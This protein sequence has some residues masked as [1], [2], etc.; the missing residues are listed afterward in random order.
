M[1][2][3]DDSIKGPVV[4]WR[5]MKDYA[6]NIVSAYR[7]LDYVCRQ[8]YEYRYARGYNLRCFKIKRLY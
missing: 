1:N 2:E 8:C 6:S 5:V 7:S 4:S 3:T